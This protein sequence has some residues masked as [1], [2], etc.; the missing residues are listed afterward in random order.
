M[1]RETKRSDKPVRTARERAERRAQTR[2]SARAA[3]RLRVEL[4]MIDAIGEHGY[5]ATRVADV[6]S[7]AGVS[8]RTF[9]EVFDNK[10]QCFLSTYD[11]IAAAVIRRLE[12]AREE[13]DTWPDAAEASIHALFEAAARNPAAARLSL[14]EI[15][16]LGPAGIQRREASVARYEDFIRETLPQGA[17]RGSVADAV[18][19]AVVGGLIRVLHSHVLRGEG[20]KLPAVVPDLAEW[21]SSY[22]P[23]PRVTAPERNRAA[24]PP[25][26]LV[27][28]RAPGTL[29]PHARMSRRRGLPRGDQNVSRSFVVH[30]QRERIL[31]AVANVTALDGYGSLNVERVAEEAA[32]S[33]NAFYEH[34]ADKEDAFLVAYEVGHAKGLALVERAYFTES[35]WRLGVRAGIAALFE[36][37]ASE[38]AFAH[39]ALVDAMIATPLTAERSN[40]GV[41]S[42]ARML[43]PRQD[44]APGQNPSP[45][46][47]I[48]AIAGGVFE[49][50]LQNMLQGTL[51]EVSE[52]TTAATYVALAPFVGPEEAGRVAAGG[53]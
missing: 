38:P 24:R 12:Q 13:V 8:S 10:Q 49:L 47:T 48:E 36:F 34:F 23:I 30:S 22:H 41:G 53:G 19:K 5:N 45:P 11:Y 6:T 27:G 14:L 28:G 26:A 3:Q 46:V 29:A 7:R 44:E 50:C 33:L 18:V 9:Y 31:D 25:S 51:G 2:E 43:V 35:D 1:A 32:V 4:A 52:L 39:L 21:A 40:V 42:F 16:A 20:A 37:L 15:N 17:S